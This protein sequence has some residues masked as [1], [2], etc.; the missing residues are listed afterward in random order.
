MATEKFG[1]MFNAE[2]SPSKSLEPN[3]TFFL[4]QKFVLE[5]SEMQSDGNSFGS[6]VVLKRFYMASSYKDNILDRIYEWL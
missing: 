6:D 2:H 4:L 5:Y 1:R 3:P